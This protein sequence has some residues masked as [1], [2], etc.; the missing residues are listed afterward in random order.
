M[1]H[2]EIRRSEAAT[3]QVLGDAD[4]DQ[5]P[6]LFI[7]GGAV[8]LDH[9]VQLF[10]QRRNSVGVVV[11]Q[12]SHINRPW[13]ILQEPDRRSLDQVFDVNQHLA[14]RACRHLIVQCFYLC[15]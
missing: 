8:M 13:R 4:L 15:P 6:G 1:S 2:P 7:P 10:G 3:R 12:R 5:A 14:L 9:G 11:D